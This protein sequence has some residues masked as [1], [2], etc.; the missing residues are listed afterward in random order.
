MKLL[1][2]KGLF[3]SVLVSQSVRKVVLVEIH[4]Y[5]DELGLTCAEEV[6][7]F[8]RPGKRI[9]ARSVTNITAPQK[10][11]VVYILCIQSLHIDIIDIYIYIIHYDYIFGYM[12]DMYIDTCS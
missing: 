9:P 3:Q 11:S 4:K 12:Q 10:R 2:W 7:S 1:Y 5:H 6:L 8:A